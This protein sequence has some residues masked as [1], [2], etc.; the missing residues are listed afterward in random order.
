[1]QK[2]YTETEE[3]KT[4]LDMRECPRIDAVDCYLPEASFRNMK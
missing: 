4:Q 2:L 1:M 3:W